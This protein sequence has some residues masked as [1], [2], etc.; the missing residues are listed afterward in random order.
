[1]PLRDRRP[2]LQPV[3]PGRG[4]APKLTRDRRRIPPQ[5]PG[6]LTH[7]F[8]LGTQQRDL[9]TLHER[10]IPARYHRWK[11]WIHAA[12]VTEPAEPN[13]AGHACFARILGP[14]APSDR[15]P[16]PDPVLPPR[17]SGTT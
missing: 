8:A 14:R 9:L 10:Q 6:D 12:S 1:M 4:V 11:T 13:R 17:D 3:G 2:V 5:P 16:E 7:P 15:R